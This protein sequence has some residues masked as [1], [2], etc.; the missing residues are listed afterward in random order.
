[1]SFIST[2]YGIFLVVVFS[3]Y[4]LLRGQRGARFGVLM[5]ASW[6]FYSMW[7]HQGVFVGWKYL[8]LIVGSTLLDYWIGGK[9][10]KL[11][12]EDPKLY[13]RRKALLMLSLVGNLGVLA[14]FKYYNWFRKDVIEALGLDLGLPVSDLLLPVGISFYTFQTLSY[15]FDIYR[16]QLKPAKNLW[17]FGLFVAF[18]P[19]LVA[20]PIVR[21]AEFLPQ[22]DKRPKLTRD[23]LHEGLFRIM[24]GLFKKVVIAD[25]IA[26][27][28]TDGVFNPAS[29][30]TGLVTLLGIYGYAL[31]IYGD[32]AGY[33]DIAI[34]SARL[35][36]FKINENFHAPYK[37]ASIQ[38]FWRRWHISLSSWLRDYLYVPLGGN[39]LGPVRTYINLAIVMLLGGLWHGANW[40]F[41]VWGAMHGVWL[42]INRW[43]QRRGWRGLSGVWGRTLAVFITFHLVCLAWVFFRSSNFVNAQH[44]LSNL[45]TGGLEPVMEGDKVKVHAWFNLPSMPISVW[46]AFVLGFGMHFLPVSTKDRVRAIFVRMPSFVLGVILALFF[47][48]LAYSAVEAQPFIYFQF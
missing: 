29:S 40:T 4:W 44:V 13:R 32:F 46:I 2:D 35:L 22:L 16:G 47:G 24:E 5:L 38:E 37:S 7:K 39:R 28:I 8:G 3:L 43:W 19:Q 26:T 17:E 34:G 14:L 9:L 11:D 23:D 15:T 36:G 20:G 18:F 33:S 48:L 6:F 21:A 1:M 30:Q 25:V 45:V 41:V 31:Q 42:G 12:H 10:A 27:G